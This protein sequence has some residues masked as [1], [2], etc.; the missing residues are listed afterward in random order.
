MKKWF[1]ASPNDLIAITVTALVIYIAL[2]LLTRLSGKRSFSKMSSFDFAMTV[3]IGSIIATVVISKS[4]S[5]AH[6]VVGLL[7]VYIIQMGAAWLRRNDAFQKLVDNEPLM[8]MDG[9]TILYENLKSAKVTV[10]I[11]KSSWSSKNRCTTTR[12]PLSSVKTR[13]R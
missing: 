10:S 13:L 4:V 11:Q 5:L 9:E 8:L 7:S 3:A 1:I 2:V 12:S 6:G